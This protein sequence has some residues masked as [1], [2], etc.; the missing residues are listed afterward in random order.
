VG[1]EQTATM[2]RNWYD[3]DKA[4]FRC[5][6]PQGVVSFIPFHDAEPMQ[7]MKPEELGLYIQSCRGSATGGGPFK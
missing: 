2:C 3:G 4:G 1:F 6:D 7:C 5:I